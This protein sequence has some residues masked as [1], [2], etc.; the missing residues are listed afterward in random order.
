MLLVIDAA[1]QGQSQRI[2]FSSTGYT[3]TGA[4][5]SI[6]TGVDMST[7]DFG[8]LAWLK[9][10]DE[11]AGSYTG[12]HILVDTVRGSFELLMSN[13][14]AAEA[15]SANYV[16]SFDSTGFS[17]GTATQVNFNTDNFISW[18]FQTTHIDTGLTN[19]NKAFTAHYNANLGFSIV[20][21]VGDCLLYTSPS[22][23]DGRLSRMPSS[24]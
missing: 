8:G 3:G 23:R 21:Y 10:R 2:G 1:S 17:L 16:T 12:D 13:T 24:A 18:S 15:T 4:A 9:S 7:G 19:R 20:G 11:G 22:P 6:N 14:T 5:R